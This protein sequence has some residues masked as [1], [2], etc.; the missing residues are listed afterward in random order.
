MM[1]KDVTVDEKDFLPKFSNAFHN[2][3]TKMPS[4]VVKA[5]RVLT[6]E[7]SKA[8][9]EFEEHGVYNSDIP[10]VVGYANTEQPYTEETWRFSIKDIMEGPSLTGR[11]FT[12]KEIQE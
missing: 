4:L 12:Y 10:L 8:K 5:Q 11:N 6:Q 3:K 9:K 2:I 7:A 1:E